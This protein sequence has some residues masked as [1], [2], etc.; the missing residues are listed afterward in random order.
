MRFSDPA[1]A[2]ETPTPTVPPDTA[3]V[4]ASTAET[5]LCALSASTLRAPPASMEEFLT[6]AETSP[7]AAPRLTSF[8]ASGLPKS[9]SCRRTTSLRRSNRSSFSWSSTS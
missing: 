1:P 8:Q 3:A 4:A 9:R 7:G 5:M 2:P 6:S